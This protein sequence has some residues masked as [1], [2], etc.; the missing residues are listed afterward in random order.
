MNPYV[1]MEEKFNESN[2]FKTMS[3]RDLS[4]QITRVSK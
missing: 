2:E 4:N 3:K 1:K